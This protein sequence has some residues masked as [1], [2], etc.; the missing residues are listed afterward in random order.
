MLLSA[1]VAVVSDSFIHSILQVRKSKDV[2]EQ[3]NKSL[4]EVLLKKYKA[5]NT[6]T[7][8]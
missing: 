2:L 7:Q 1:L 5:A 3:L 6:A 8:A 4:C